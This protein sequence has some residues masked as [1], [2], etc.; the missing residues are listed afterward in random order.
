MGYPFYF[1]Y[2]FVYSLMMFSTC[3]ET[4]KSVKCFGYNGKMTTWSLLFSFLLYTFF[5][6][7]FAG[8]PS[9][10]PL[11]ILCLGDS[12][13]QSVNITY[14]YRYHLWK[15]MVDLDMHVDF[16]GSMK[17]CYPE[18]DTLSGDVYRGRRFDREH[19]GHWGWQA[20]QI[21][22]MEKEIPEG[23]GS[24]NLIEWLKGY[25][26]D[27]VLLHI[28]HN[29]AGLGEPPEETAEEL[30]KII[31]LLQKDN[32]N[33]SILLAKVIPTDNPE[34]NNRL[35]SLNTAI[36][37]VADDTKTAHLKIFIIDFSEDFNAETDTF[38][39]IHTNKKGAEKM[40]RKWIKGI[41]QLNQTS[42]PRTIEIPASIR[43]K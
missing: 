2:T 3:D 39:G 4:E 18:I 14:S 11:R 15:K 43:I 37:Q 32:P 23:T 42:H 34:W 8:E 35:S 6:V 31:L 41:L 27:I 10:K 1:S 12:I 7:C 26:P 30:K 25:T 13:T 36:Q 5:S 22:G 28:G 38:D 20:D 21:L 24:G 29:D 16:I 19:E 33:V 40:A 9:E 17:S